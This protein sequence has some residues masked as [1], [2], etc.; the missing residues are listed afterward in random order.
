MAL[1]SEE[2]EE[3]I[4]AWINAFKG[5]IPGFGKSK[6]VKYVQEGSKALTF[7]K[8]PSSV[9]VGSGAAKTTV[10]IDKAI[11][12][13]AGLE[14]VPDEY[15]QHIFSGDISLKIVV[16]LQGLVGSGTITEAEAAA[17]IDTKYHYVNVDGA[18]FLW[19][20]AS[21]NAEGSGSG[22][23]DVEEEE[24]GPQEDGGENLAA[25]VANGSDA[26]P[27][28][29]IQF[30]ADVGF[31]LDQLPAQY[32]KGEVQD[33][34][35]GALE[36]VLDEIGNIASGKLSFKPNSIPGTA[37][38]A[39]TI[40]PSKFNPL[41]FSQVFTAVPPPEEAA[42][43]TIARDPSN[44]RYLTRSDGSQTYVGPGRVWTVTNVFYPESFN[45]AALVK[46]YRI[47]VDEAS[48]GPLSCGLTEPVGTGALHAQQTSSDWECVYGMVL[49]GIPSLGKK[50]ELIMAVDYVG[51]V[52]ASLNSVFPSGVSYTNNSP[53]FL[54]NQAQQKFDTVPPL[55]YQ[56]RYDSALANGGKQ[57]LDPTYL[58]PDYLDEI[59][60]LVVQLV[61]GETAEQIFAELCGRPSPAWGE[62]GGGPRGSETSAPG[63]IVAGPPMRS[64]AVDY[65][66]GGWYQSEG[67]M[68]DDKRISDGL[69]LRWG[70][71]A[72]LRRS[73][74]SFSVSI[75]AWP[76][77]VVPNVTGTVSGS[78]GN[79]IYSLSPTFSDCQ[80]PANWPGVGIDLVSQGHRD[81][82]IDILV[83]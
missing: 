35:E 33:A 30:Q 75:Q 63:G 77:R 61:K 10:G 24:A 76:P 50:P 25:K 45:P 13:K 66:G 46:R 22:V 69:P 78:G 83:A 79:F 34:I 17:F 48:L 71:L 57:Y 62:L 12:T 47:L 49:R 41:G 3:Q 29:S 74:T 67:S 1:L 82:G 52:P 27:D 53:R 39:G 43:L 16:L 21:V 32:N 28:L 54:S 31:E 40:P 15:E 72:P 56:R 7:S 60:G 8:K 4:L 80:R 55:L 70:D 64:I 14:I 19:K 2:K 18:N 58:T 38:I 20:P 36:Q 73:E 42:I 23:T 37:L 81:F 6:Y 44:D 68:T 59:E 5:S 51:D 9:T 26:A 65:N 11:Y